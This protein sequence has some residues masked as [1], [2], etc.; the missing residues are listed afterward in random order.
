MIK[1]K[2]PLHDFMG[3]PLR[4]FTERFRYQKQTPLIWLESL[5]W[6]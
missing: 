1:V 4:I 5:C 3:V 6:S 2:P